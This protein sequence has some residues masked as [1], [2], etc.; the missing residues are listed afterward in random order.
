M[1]KAQEICLKLGMATRKNW[2]IENE[3]DVN[4]GKQRKPGEWKGYYGMRGWG[5]YE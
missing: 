4:P 1:K 3:S 5:E 2:Y